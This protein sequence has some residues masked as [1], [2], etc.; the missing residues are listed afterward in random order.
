MSFFFSF[1]HYLHSFTLSCNHNSGPFSSLPNPPPT[2][3]SHWPTSSLSISPTVSLWLFW[4]PW[5][6]G[7]RL[8]TWYLMADVTSL[9]RRWPAGPALLRNCHVCVTRWKSPLRNPNAAYNWQ[10]GSHVWSVCVCVCVK[11]IVWTAKGPAAD[12]LGECNCTCDR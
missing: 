12:G 5:S 11:R 2:L 7:A 8:L 9:L 1:L 6:P 4:H 10:A 3:A